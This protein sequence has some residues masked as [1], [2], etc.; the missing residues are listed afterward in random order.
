MVKPGGDLVFITPRSFCSG[1]YY[2]KIREWFIKNTSFQKFHIFES[3]K[4]VFCEEKIQQETIIFHTVKQ[5]S[6]PDNKVKISLSLDRKFELK[7]YFKVSHSDIISNKK[8]ES[9]IRLPT[10]NLELK[11]I[12]VVDSWNHTLQDIGLNISTGPIVDFR[13]K[14]SVKENISNE[15]SVPLLWMQNMID[16]KIVWPN[17][18]SHN[19]QAIEINEKTTNYLL[20]INNYV[21]LRRVTSKEQKR[22]LCAT[23][24]NK[25]DFKKFKYVG[26]ENHLNYI[27]K[28]DGDLSEN[29]TI[30][31][32]ALLNTKIIDIYFR[33]L[34]GNNQVNATEMRILPLPEL[35]Q[36]RSIG[37]KILGK[38]MEI[39]Y[40]MDFVVANLLKIDIK[41]IDE[42]YQ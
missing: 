39:G 37:K 16:G 23:A 1:Y 35:N 32:V 8:S 24:F 33:V 17:T 4:N 13:N 27:Y 7:N 10:S 12:E 6:L 3:R 36:L 34:N 9:F 22:R 31:L 42:I 5:P 15:F 2:K 38:K 41:L 29:E 11:I 19:N 30:G 40:E 25:H 21:L 26:F 18:I 14:E 20:P 28:N